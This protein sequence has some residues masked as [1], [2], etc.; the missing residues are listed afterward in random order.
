MVGQTGLHRGD[1]IFDVEGDLRWRGD[2]PSFDDD[3]CGDMGGEV[4]NGTVKLELLLLSFSCGGSI[5]DEDLLLM[6]SP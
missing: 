2:D 1:S 4:L 6:R 5:C 3:V